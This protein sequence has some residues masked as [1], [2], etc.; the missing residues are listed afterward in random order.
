MKVIIAILYLLPNL[1]A[2]T[3]QRKAL[4]ASKILYNPGGR[5]VGRFVIS[6]KD[7]EDIRIDSD[8]DGQIDHWYLRKG[9]SEVHVSFEHGQPS[10]FKIKH[11]G[12]KIVSLV[13]YNKVGQKFLLES[14]TQRAPILMNLSEEE[15]KCE[16]EKIQEKMKSFAE[17]IQETSLMKLI[18]TKLVSSECYENL[19]KKELSSIQSGLKSSLSK[20]SGLNSCLTDPKF[21][22]LAKENNTLKTPPELLI[23][24]YQL[25][26]AQLTHQI[27]DNSPLIRCEPVEGQSAVISTTEKRQIHINTPLLEKNKSRINSTEIEHEL[28]HR[29]GLESEDDVKV[30]ESICIKKSMRLASNSTNTKSFQG[31]ISNEKVS[32]AI[33]DVGSENTANVKTGESKRPDASAQPKTKGTEVAKSPAAEK[34]PARAPAATGN[35]VAASQ[36]TANIPKEMTVA[37]TSIPEAP[38]LSESISNPAPATEAGSQQALTR[39]ASESSG[40][41]RMANNLVGAMNSRAT[42]SDTLADKNSDTSS[43]SEVSSSSSSD[44]K[45]ASSSK[46]KSNPFA[47]LSRD[48]VGSGERVVEQITLDGNNV[49]AASATSSSSREISG[50]RVAQAAGPSGAKN[51]APTGQ[52]EVARGTASSGSG[53]S[54]GGGPGF[55]AATPS[56]GGSSGGSPSRAPAAVNPSIEAKQRPT[57][58]KADNSAPRQQASANVSR[59]EVVTF[60]SNNSYRVTKEKLQKP[61]FKKQLETQKITVLDLYGNTVGA[62]RGEVIFLDQGDRFVRQK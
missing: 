53:F 34:A 61:E 60:I 38:R 24:R 11:V 37:Q 36:A 44:S 57:D 29:A 8:W 46:A 55:N 6:Y 32:Q 17:N 3:P 7:Y 18:D 49:Q 10:H 41:L 54:G 39:S 59:D 23:A 20:R 1:W 15:V 12:S 28:L 50:A 22:E 30:V 9:A 21:L 5:E 42:A 26:A 51:N 40:V 58:Q 35:Q 43:K 47:T 45:S 14:A 2:Q 16:I 19:E 13:S 31:I 52:G 27:E 33:E 62:P 56:M 48:K 25:Q 4:D